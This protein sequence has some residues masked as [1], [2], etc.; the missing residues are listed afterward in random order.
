MPFGVGRRV[1]V[2]AAFA[3]AEATLILAEL[4]SRYEITLEDPRPV[5]PVGM[6][7]GPSIEPWF[8]LQ[9]RGSAA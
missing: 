8:R 7:L 1:C 5:R 2:G 9:S 6:V 4:L 3:M